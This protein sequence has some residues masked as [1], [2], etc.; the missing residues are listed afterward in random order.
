[1]GSNVA[2]GTAYSTN[3]GSGI[4][5]NVSQAS[6]SATVGAY[7]PT[8]T[9]IAYSISSVPANLRIVLGTT[10]TTQYC[11]N[12]AAGATT[13]TVPWS[14]F[15][16]DC[17]DTVPDGGTFSTADGL[18]KVQ[19]QVAAAAAPATYEFCVNSVSF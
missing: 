17:W 18:A 13:G 10:G 4:G 11:S 6:G 19:F 3:W 2:Q 15:V 5:I 12:V 9:G 7:T 1:M 16:T 8:G 14:S